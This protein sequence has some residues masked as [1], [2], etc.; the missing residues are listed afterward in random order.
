MS[1]IEEKPR[2]FGWRQ[3]DIIS[4]NYNSVL[5]VASI[6]KKPVRSENINFVVIDFSSI[7]TLCY[8]EE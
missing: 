5:I 2:H 7:V 6:D 4:P 8:S 3:G 1:A